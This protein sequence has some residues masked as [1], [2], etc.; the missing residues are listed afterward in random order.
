MAN[1]KFNAWMFC[2]FI[3]KHGADEP[4]FAIYG[5]QHNE[6]IKKDELLEKYLSAETRGMANPS[7]NPNSL[8]LQIKHHLADQA[9]LK[10]EL[11]ELR[12]FFHYM[13]TAGYI[14]IETQLGDVVVPDGNLDNNDAVFEIGTV[15]QDQYEIKATVRLTN[16]GIEFADSTVIGVFLK[17]FTWG[18]SLLALVVSLFA[19]GKSA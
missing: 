18:I 7:L 9:K 15:I 16:S 8:T 4:T 14:D 11:K 13:D 5:L 17:E 10:I 6:I 3:K 2:R 12:K 1:I 19:L